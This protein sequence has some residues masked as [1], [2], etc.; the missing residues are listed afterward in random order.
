MTYRQHHCRLKRDLLR[1][2]P[3]LLFLLALFAVQRWEWLA[4]TGCVGAQPPTGAADAIARGFLAY[5]LVLWIIAA[6]AF[7]VVAAPLVL[8]RVRLAILDARLHRLITGS[9]QEHVDEKPGPG[10]CPNCRCHLTGNTSNVC[11]ECG[12][13]LL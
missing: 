2:S 9:G 10:Y 4:E 12:R 8:I 13:S 7:A 6:L 11:P 5:V 3:F 1:A